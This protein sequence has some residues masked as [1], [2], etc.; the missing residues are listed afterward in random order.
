MLIHPPR[1]TTEPNYHWWLKVRALCYGS[2]CET[3]LMFD[4][5]EEAFAIKKGYMFL[6]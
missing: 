6:S 5:K 4:S 1:I 3:T 2:E